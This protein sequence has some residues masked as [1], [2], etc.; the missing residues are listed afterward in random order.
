MVEGF[1]LFG[2]RYLWFFSARMHRREPMATI[3][4]RREQVYVKKGT[5]RHKPV[6]IQ[7]RL[8]VSTVIFYY[9]VIRL[10]ICQSYG[11]GYGYRLPCGC[12]CI[13]LYNIYKVEALKFEAIL[14][15]KH[16]V[17]NPNADSITLIGYVLVCC[18]T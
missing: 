5:R 11:N 3:G 1:S 4:V 9:G 10:A 2:L 13:S 17:S 8:Q 15:D 14:V 6:P 7:Q 16:Y 18:S 12:L